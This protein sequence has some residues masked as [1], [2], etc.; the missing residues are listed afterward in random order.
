MKGLE[1][2]KRTS[3]SFLERFEGKK[4]TISKEGLIHLFE[5][6]QKKIISLPLPLPKS[7]ERPNHLQPASSKEILTE[8]VRDIQRLGS[9]FRAPKDHPTSRL[10]YRTEVLRNEPQKD[11]LVLPR[12]AGRFSSSH[13]KLLSRPEEGR[14]AYLNMEQPQKKQI[15]G[16]NLD[17][18]AL[19]HL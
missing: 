5:Q 9:D 16:K 8:R 17:E 14:K 7:T 18:N 15:F 19:E 11:D 6:H 3:S 1:Q 13:Q 4:S 10:S 12:I 2:N